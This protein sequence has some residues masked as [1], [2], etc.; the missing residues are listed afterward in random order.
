[1]MELVDSTSIQT[2]RCSLSTATA[3]RQTASRPPEK[4]S[5][6]FTGGAGGARRAA[7]LIRH[8]LAPCTP[9]LTLAVFL[10]PSAFHTS[11]PRSFLEV[12]GRNVSC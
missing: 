10:R 1:M 7:F 4:V 8:V 2:N 12:D 5:G 9:T 3:M 11:P 6:V